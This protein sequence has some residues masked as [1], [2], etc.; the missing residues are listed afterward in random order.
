MRINNLL[1]RLALAAGS[2]ILGCTLGLAQ[3]TTPA[4]AKKETAPA[5]ATKATPAPH[6]EKAAKPPAA[7]KQLM[8]LPGIGDAYADKIIAGRRYAKKSD[9]KT[10]KVV[11]ATTYSKIDSH[12]IVKPTK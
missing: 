9:L 12:V 5:P 6:S 4:P 3:A 10:K 8:A 7:A 2:V 1:P 11:P